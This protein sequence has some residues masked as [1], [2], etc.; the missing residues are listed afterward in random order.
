M[1]RMLFQRSHLKLIRLRTEFR[2]GAKTAVESARRLSFQIRRAV[3][4]FGKPHDPDGPY[5]MVTAPTRP[6]LPRRSGAVAV[7]PFE[8]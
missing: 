5:S 1:T 3:T 7:D 2:R 4:S 8:Y 6:R